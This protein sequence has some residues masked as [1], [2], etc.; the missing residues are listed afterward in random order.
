MRDEQISKLQLKHLH[1]LLATLDEILVPSPDVIHLAI[2][3]IN[4][5]ASKN[6]ADFRSCMKNLGI[7]Q[8]RE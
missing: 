7:F 2:Q 4:V 3:T 5:L 8:L 1:S 6:T